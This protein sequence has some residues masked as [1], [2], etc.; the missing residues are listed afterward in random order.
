MNSA[1]RLRWLAGLLLFSAI[2]L[3]GIYWWRMSSNHDQ[4]RADALDKAGNRASQL[5]ELQ[6]RHIE[7]LFLGIDQT[8]LQFRSARQ[9]RNNS[10][11]EA[12]VHTA[13][14]SFPPGSLTGFL[15]S[16]AE[17]FVAYFN[18]VNAT[19]HGNIVYHSTKSPERYYV[20]DREYFK[21]H[22]GSSKDRLFISKPIF[23]RTSG[24]WAIPITRPLFEKNRFAGVVIASFSV[25]YLAGMLAKMTL[26]SDDVAAILYRDG[27]YVARSQNLHEVIGKAVPR[28]RPFL[29]PDAP[30]RGVFHATGAPD[31]VPRIFAWHK[32]EGHPLLA[33]IGL[34]ERVV[35]APIEQQIDLNCERGAVAIGLILALI[36]AISFLLMRAARQQRKLE[37]TQFSMDNSVAPI[38]W[39]SPDARIQLVNEAACQ[40]WGYSREEMLDLTLHDIDPLFTVD[41]WRDFWI[42]LKKNQ[43]SKFETVHRTKDGRVIPVEVTAKYIQ[44]DGQ[45][46]SFAFWVDLS[47][48]KASADMIW[49]QVNYDSLTGLPNRRMFLDRLEQEIRKAHRTGT[50]MALLFIDLDDFKDINDTLGHGVGDLLLKEAAQRLSGC[51]RNTDTVARMGGDEFIVILGDLQST[52]SAERVAREIRDKLAA[53]FQLGDDL[54]YISTSIGITLYPDDAANTDDL[55]KNADQAMY[56]AKQQGKNRYHYFTPSMQQAAQERMRLINDMRGAL[57]GNQFL[58]HYQPIVELATGS[59]HKAEALVRWQ[60][61]VRG[62]ISPAEF[63]PLAEDTGMIVAIGDWVFKEAAHQVKR[64]RELYDPQ[65]KIS[66]NKSPVQ[67][68][69]DSTLYETWFDCLRDLNLPGESMVIEITESLLMDSGAIIIDRLNAFRNAGIQ[70]SLDDFGTGYS[71]L[72]YLKNFNLDYLKID[73]SFV[74]NLTPDSEDMVLCEA[75]IEMAHKLGIKVIAEGVETGEQLDLLTA[76]GC[77]YAQGYLFSRPISAEELEKL[78]FT[79]SCS[80]LSLLDA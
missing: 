79:D 2:V 10:G 39:I 49:R 57:G 67:F 62:L 69:K 20:K 55:L 18:I 73:Q 21:F 14:D 33:V 26:G 60:H 64:V 48:K 4:L 52:E 66:V 3:S 25:D 46:Y 54:A 59:I 5:A 41:V 23:G 43:S 16:D 77:D 32:L 78:L 53:P 15:A 70:L 44:H 17:G 47:D 38:S 51:V 35:L 76:A 6:A 8:L 11:A 34:D 28:D 45:E 1:S 63:I 36:T 74:R 12:I 30:E 56:A 9:A 50:Q 24:K 42:N 37:L 29:S 61:P 68:R 71:S 80:A 72:S 27:T 58:V 19:E 65:F 13:L 31:Q 7:A 40:H 22:H 75:I